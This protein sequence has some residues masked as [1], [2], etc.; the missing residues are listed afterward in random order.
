ME[1]NCS[2]EQYPELWKRNVDL[3]CSSEQYPGT[4]EEKCGSELFK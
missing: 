2:S 3:N 4:V 1:V